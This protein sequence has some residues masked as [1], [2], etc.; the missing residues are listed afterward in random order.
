MDHPN[1]ARSIVSGVGEDVIDGHRWAEQ[2]AVLRFH[3]LPLGELRFQAAI[4]LPEQLLQQ[5]GVVTLNVLFDGQP[6]H[7]A[8]FTE[9]G[10]HQIEKKLAPGEVT[11]ERETE[12]TL[13]MTTPNSNRV[14]TT[15]T[16]YL[17]AA[18]GFRF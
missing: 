5:A 18:A 10:R 1:A 11:W 13:Q 9:P 17:L 7:Q 12:V 16:R 4:T 6:A 2:R 14:P 3:S 8:E 15:D